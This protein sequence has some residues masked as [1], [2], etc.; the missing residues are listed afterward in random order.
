[1]TS[2]KYVPLSSENL[3]VVI[4]LT[5]LLF[6]GL[7][8]TDIHL[9]ALPE[10]MDFMNTN[11]QLMQ[12]SI[13]I[14][15]LGVGASSL[16]Y[17]PLSDKY[18][19]KPVIIVGLFIAIFGNL[20]AV[21]LSTIEPFLIARFV[22]GIGCGVCIALPRIVL[23]DI[24]QGERYAITSSYITLFTGLSIVLGP[25][26]GS[27]IQSWYGW[28]ANF[29]AMALM[30]FFMLIMYT[31]LCP[32]T[33]KYKNQS[34]QLVN[35]F[36]NYRLVLQNKI[37]FSATLLAGIGMTCFVMYTS[38][39]SFVLQ[40]QFGLSPTAYGWM[41]AFVGS[42]LLMS[43]FLLPK[44]IRRY[45]MNQMILTGLFILIICGSSLLI[46]SKLGYLTIASF[47]LSV[48]GIFFSYTFIV[49][50]ASAISMTPFTDK[51]GSA[52]AVY[53][54]S[55]MALAFAV[56]S[57]VSLLSDNAVGILGVSYIALP[58]LGIYLLRKMQSKQ[59]HII[60]GVSSS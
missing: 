59:D 43:R 19:R 54:C 53:S 39:S 57:I 35:V 29:I 46:F 27:F 33:N 50:C 9:S 42:G 48:A 8:G 36:T 38:S 15:L 28:K 47:L 44:F 7:L 25:V 6:I 34:I 17:G 41:S 2:T 51:R 5:F 55:Q 22:Q 52:G 60:S 12:S 31:W 30:I 3:I 45:G 4:I 16:I 49:L 21:T 40:E 20:W 26:L 58:V 23:S 37:F 11:Q 13:S 32:E 24:V 56:N 10:M 18:G 1:M 14:F